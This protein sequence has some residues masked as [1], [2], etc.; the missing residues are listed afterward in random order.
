MIRIRRARVKDAGYIQSLLKKYT[1]GADLIVRPLEDIYE[2]IRDYFVLYEKKN[3][4]GAVA[5]HVYWED[6]G[7]IRSFVIEKKCRKQGLGDKLITH[8]LKEAKELGLKKVFA[9]T[10][11]PEYFKRKGFSAIARKNLPHKI[12]KDCFSCPKF[13]KCDEQAVIYHI[14]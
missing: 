12:W 13:P 6:L 7:E 2:Q 8:A 14:K 9:L 11:I 4:Y 5:L 3:I 10:K 1:P